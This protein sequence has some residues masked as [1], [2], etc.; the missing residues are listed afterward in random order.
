[1]CFT[2]SRA[3]RYGSN[4]NI[5][6]RA[7]VCKLNAVFLEAIVIVNVVNATVDAMVVSPTG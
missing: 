2:Y 5:L 3:Q 1:M 4:A 7:H 6:G